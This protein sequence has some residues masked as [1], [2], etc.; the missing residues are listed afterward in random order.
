MTWMRPRSAVAHVLAAA[1]VAAPAPVWARVACADRPAGGSVD[2]ASRLARAQDRLAQA[3]YA[4]AAALAGA[5][6]R[7]ATMLACADRA[8]AFR[9][10]GLALFFLRLPAEAEAALLEF[11]RLEPEAHLDPALVAPEAIV[12]FEDVRARHAGELATYKPRP[13]R[14]RYAALNLL[15]P[16]GQFQNGE[17]TKGWILAAAGGALLVTNV[18]TYVLLRRN[19]DDDTLVCSGGADKARALRSVNL[20][21]GALFWGVAAYG[22]VDGFLVHRR[23]VERERLGPGAR[24]FLVPATGGAALVLTHRF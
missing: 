4:G 5:L 23:L 7:D 6:A 22:V 20:V 11:L 3:D 2:A 10:Y 18:T 24:A 14:R 1:L 8:E 15:P 17:P 9:I 16:L 19:C 13:R 21:S 12:F